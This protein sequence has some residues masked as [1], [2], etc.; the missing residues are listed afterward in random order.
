MSV[1]GD[2]IDNI[3]TALKTITVANGYNQTV[4]KVFADELRLPEELSLDEIP[5]LFIV[6]GDE[7]KDHG[8]IDSVKCSLEIIV[9]GVVRKDNDQ[10]DVQDKRRKLQNDV[11]KCLMVDESRGGKAIYTQ[12]KRIA[13]DKMTIGDYSIF[14]IHFDIGYFHDRG[15]PSSQSN[16]PL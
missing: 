6:D 11:E 1:R 2:I 16:S 12:A 13:T 7:N 8:D 9:E 14:D 3:E 10:E 5:A 15:D 4:K